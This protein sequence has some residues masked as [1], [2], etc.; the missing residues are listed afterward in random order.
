MFVDAPRNV[1]VT[2]HFPYAKCAL[3]PDALLCAKTSCCVPRGA[4][5][6]GA[7]A[8]VCARSCTLPQ[9]QHCSLGLCPGGSLVP[10][11]PCAHGLPD[12]PGRHS[13][14]PHSAST[15]RPAARLL[16]PRTCTPSILET[17]PGQGCAL[18]LLVLMSRNLTTAGLVCQPIPHGV[19]GLPPG[20]LL[21]GRQQDQPASALPGLPARLHL[22]RQRLHR[23]HT[24]VASFN[25]FGG[26]EVQHGPCSQL[27]HADRGEEGVGTS[28]SGRGGRREQPLSC[29]CLGLSGWEFRVEGA[30]RTWR[31]AIRPSWGPG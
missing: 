1:Q 30:G 6:E 3:A 17:W 9:H 26:W 8:C 4:G 5:G 24:C 13:A 27:K 11:Q 31:L 29:V 23:L 21:A 22:P 12:G 10:L 18:S 16:H 25:C 15:S 14:H 2:S 28:G 20:Q 7:R 19:R